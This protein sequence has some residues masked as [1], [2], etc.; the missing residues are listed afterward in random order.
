MIATLITS[1][2]PYIVG[3][4]AAIVAAVSLYF[5]GKAKGTANAETK[6]ALQNAANS[7]AEAKASAETV[8]KTIGSAA[9]ETNSVNRLDSGAS[10]DKLRNEWSRD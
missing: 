4:A 7:V 2:A 6:A 8:T 3:I 9:N 1:A 10:A 5:G